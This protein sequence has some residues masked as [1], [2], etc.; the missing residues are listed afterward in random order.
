MFNKALLARQGWRF[1]QHSN[2]L[3][4]R[5]LK[6]KY[7]PHTSFLEAPVPNN[8][9]Y[10]WRSLC[11]SR[12]VLRASLRWCVGTDTCI[13]AW[14]DAWLPS[15]TTYKVIS[16]VRGLSEEATMDSLIDHDLKCWNID[17]LGQGLLPRDVEIIKQITLSK[18][19]PSDRL[20]W[21]GTSNVKF[22]VRSAYHLLL[23]EQDRVLE[24]TSRGMGASQ[25][26]WS[27][28]WSAKVQPKIR[29]FMWRACLDILPTRTKLFD[30]GILSFFTC[31]WCEDDPETTSHVL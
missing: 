13:K 1:L 21:T 19:R 15:P 31:Q 12:H 7:F 20:I 18:R 17:L 26:L 16:S 11:E 4:Y 6:A 8:V 3:V 5:F 2:S 27:A 9:S 24:S 22:T 23:H 14:T 25:H 29:V 10:I 30:R 28:I